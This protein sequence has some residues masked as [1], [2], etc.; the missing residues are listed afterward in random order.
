MAMAS[1]NLVDAPSYMVPPSAVIVD[2]PGA[3]AST[4]IYGDALP[5][6]I[7]SLGLETNSIAQ[8]N[9]CIPSNHNR[10]WY[11]SAKND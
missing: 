10:C 4:Y 5:A 8:S 1:N 6:L 9:V 3:S 2:G 7:V 11:L